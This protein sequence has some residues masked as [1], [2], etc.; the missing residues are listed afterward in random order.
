MLRQKGCES[1]E[2]TKLVV[3]SA[4]LCPHSSRREPLHKQAPVLQGNVCFASRQIL[5]GE[6]EKQLHGAWNW[7]ETHGSTFLSTAWAQH[8]LHIHTRVCS[9]A[10]DNLTSSARKASR[11]AALPTTLIF[12]VAVNMRSLNAPQDGQV[13]ASGSEVGGSSHTP[14]STA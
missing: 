5:H 14:L 2:Y 3:N 9:S 6:A 4:F 12:F 11:T 1:Q 7:E 8:L 13:F 10:G